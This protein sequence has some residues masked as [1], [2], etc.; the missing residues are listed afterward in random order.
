MNF[1]RKNEMK[2]I[3]TTIDYVTGIITEKYKRITTFYQ[4]GIVTQF[5]TKIVTFVVG[6][7]IAASVLFGSYDESRQADLMTTNIYQETP[8]EQLI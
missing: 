6:S 3:C 8:V 1:E 2:F 5:K 7:L 4:N